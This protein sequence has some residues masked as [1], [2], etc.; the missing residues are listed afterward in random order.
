MEVVQTI[1]AREVARAGRSPRSRSMCREYWPVWRCV[2][3]VEAFIHRDSDWRRRHVV[4]GLEPLQQRF[5]LWQTIR[6]QFE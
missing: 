2:R 4:V 1:R 5:D 3:P 6:P